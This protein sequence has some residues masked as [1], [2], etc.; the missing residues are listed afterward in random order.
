MS[1]ADLVREILSRQG[2]IQDRVRARRLGDHPPV[3]LGQVYNGGSIPTT[4]GR[5]ALTVPASFAGNETE[6]ATATITTDGTRTVPVLVLGT[7]PGTGQN[8]L[9]R[10]VNGLWVTQLR[11]SSGGGT[12]SVGSLPFNVKG[13]N[14]SNLAGATVSVT[15]PGGYAQ[16]GTTDASGNI[17]FSIIGYPSGTYSYSVSY[18][19]F[20]TVSGSR[21]A[22]CTTNGTVSITLTP[23]ATHA[24]MTCCPKAYPRSITF[25]S[26]FGTGA[27]ATYTGSGT[28]NGWSCTTIENVPA[29]SDSGYGTFP[30][31][32]S[33]FINCN[34]SILGQ[35]FY[36]NTYARCD[37]ADYGGTDTGGIG[38]AGFY[39]YAD[40]HTLGPPYAPSATIFWSIPSSPFTAVGCSGTFFSSQPCVWR[41]A[42]TD[43]FGVPHVR[44]Y[45]LGTATAVE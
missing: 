12:C 39:L 27:T 11:S 20:T 34:G 45:T 26:P 16:L 19:G 18:T 44:N 43:G 24:C 31:T 21:I 37:G 10:N 40:G 22:T 28:G 14:G 29:F 38:S 1:D 2:D 23:D 25:T 30:V 33:W 3:Y 7:A 17:T 5:I 9:A 42:W 36:G 4:A 13:C 41:F 32:I 6:N 15:G 8:V 35:Q